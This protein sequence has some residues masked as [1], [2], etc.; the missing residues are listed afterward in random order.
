MEVPSFVA[1][2]SAFLLSVLSA[3]RG[4]H[5]LGAAGVD[6][7]RAASA[8]SR[9]DVNR[10]VARRLVELHHGTVTVSSEGVG[11]GC[12]FVVTLPVAH[13]NETA[14]VAPAGRSLSST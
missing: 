1:A 10:E 13:I 3:L 11:R 9:C 7:V 5:F 2:F 6:A 4:L 8:V 14:A 12:E